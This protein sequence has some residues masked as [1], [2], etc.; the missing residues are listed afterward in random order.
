MGI[1]LIITGHE[2]LLD[3]LLRLCAAAGCTP[4]V[5]TEP[6]V[7]VGSW[8]TAGLVLVGVDVSE[9]V[10][11]LDLPRRPGVHLVG[12]DRV[13]DQAFRTAVRI[14]AE[15]VAELPRSEAWVLETLAEA[16]EGGARQALTLGVLGG[17]GG[18]GATTFACSLALAAA[19][20]GPACLLD[21]DPQGPGVD[22]VLGF[23][24]ADGVRWG[25]LQQTT[26]RISA[27]SLREA[28]PRRERL[29]VLTWAT[30]AQSSLQAFTVREAMSAAVRGHDLVVVD[31]PRTGSALT[32]ELAARCDHLVV[33]VR[34]TLPGLASAAR[35]VAG[36]SGSGPVSLVVR[37]PGVDPAEVARAVGAP[38]LATMSDQR[39]LDEAVD[40]G[41]GPLR[42]RRGVLSRAA[43]RVLDGVGTGHLAGRSAA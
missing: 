43:E 35:V 33:T 41:L 17:S 16:T 29:G 40:L 13:P 5:A 8:S 21:T 34:A 36:A 3:D 14:G 25:A 42:S 26:G 18:S 1:P 31:L 23:D 37:G 15:N 9:E 19:R 11:R 10:A 32:E 28:L 22:R 12:W 4:E 7:V 39:G 6:G 27:R 24:D 38:V 30:G 20:R 2:T